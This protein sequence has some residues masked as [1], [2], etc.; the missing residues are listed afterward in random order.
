MRT[1]RI[2]G[3]VVNAFLSQKLCQGRIDGKGGLSPAYVRSIMLIVD[4]AL[5]FAAEER[6]C[7]P[8]PTRI[9][10]PPVRPRELP[11]LTAEDQKRLEKVL[12]T[13]MDATKLGIY[14]SLYT[15]LRIGEVCA[16][17]WEDVDLAGR[18]IYVRHTAARIR[19]EENG[20]AVTRYVIDR[21]KTK[22]SL[23]CVPICSRLLEVLTA[24]AGTGAS[25]YVASD[26]PG[27]LNPRTLE[28]RYAGLLRSSGIPYVNFHGLRHT[29]ATRCVEAG[30]DVKSLSEI[31]GHASVSVTLNTY[32]HSSMERKRAELE[33]LMA[34]P[35]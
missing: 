35:A 16:L 29:F 31:L 4:S 5:R 19:C 14:I 27:F 3:P 22:S 20:A 28:Y 7:A 33:K 30:M 8:L 32:V 13:G 6:L 26:R 24:L 25:A 34:L 21:P 2:T 17:A 12:R 18:V 11:V 23:R 10:K 9:S 15:G 1:D